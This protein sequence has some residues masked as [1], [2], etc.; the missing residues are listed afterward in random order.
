M[1]DASC[2]FFEG[3]LKLV[4]GRAQVLTALINHFSLFYTCLGIFYF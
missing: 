4:T 2:D 3:V 1:L